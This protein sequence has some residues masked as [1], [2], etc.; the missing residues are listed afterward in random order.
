MGTTLPI[1]TVGI[2]TEDD[3][4]LA[5]RRAR[6][7]SQSLGFNS[8]D[9]TRI[10]TALSEISRNALEYSDG[11][12]VAFAIDNNSGDHQELVIRVS[13]RGAGI[14]D[15]PAVLSPQF[16]SRTG[17]GV[18]IRGSRALMDRFDIASVV[19]EGTTVTM[20]KRLPWSAPRFGSGD[21]T[22]LVDRIAKARGGTALNEMQAQNQALLQTL[23][24][25]SAKNL[26]VE[27]LR[28]V[29]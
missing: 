29:A 14:A 26:E 2:K 5:R 7:I 25:L 19:G 9:I 1:L 8:G 27:R 21:V 13:D 6:E 16:Q 12:S 4:M 18:G 28:E 24:E 15:V 11:G 22:R 20:S 3:L 23:G 17:M 10:I